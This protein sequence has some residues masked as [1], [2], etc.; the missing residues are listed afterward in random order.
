M[1]SKTLHNPTHSHKR[2]WEQLF[3][4]NGD[5]F[6]YEAVECLHQQSMTP[7]SASANAKCKTCRDLSWR[8]QSLK[9]GWIL[10]CRSQIGRTDMMVYKCASCDFKKEFRRTKFSSHKTEKVKCEA[11]RK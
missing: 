8:D 7:K 5:K 3:R 11:C 2:N 10:I 4:L 1:P 6:Q 9:F